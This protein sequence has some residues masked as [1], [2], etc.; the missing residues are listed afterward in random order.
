[1]KITKRNYFL[2]SLTL[3]AAVAAAFVGVCAAA[4]GETFSGTAVVGFA[5]FSYVA[6]N[7][8]QMLCAAYRKKHPEVYE[9]L[10]EVL[11]G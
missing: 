10:D 9:K 8:V 11:R 7:W 5:C 1:M 6:G 4:E 3:N 2:V